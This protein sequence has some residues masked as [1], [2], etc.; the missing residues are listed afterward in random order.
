M[1]NLSNPTPH[2]PIQNQRFSITASEGSPDYSFQWRVNDEDAQTKTQAYPTL[3]IHVPAGTQ[4]EMLH[5]S[6]TDGGGDSANDEWMITVG[7]QGM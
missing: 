3:T 1:V 6:V 7:S 5:V 4:G 2:S